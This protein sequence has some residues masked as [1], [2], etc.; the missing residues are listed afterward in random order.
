MADE[1]NGNF[2]DQPEKAQDGPPEVDLRNH[3]HVPDDHG[4]DDLA[5]GPK[6]TSDLDPASEAGPS[7]SDHSGPGL[8]FEGLSTQDDPL[9]QGE[10]WPGP[11]DD[12]DDSHDDGH[13][14]GAD[15]NQGPG[16][17]SVKNHDDDHKPTAPG[18]KDFYEESL[19]NE[20]LLTPGLKYAILGV[21]FILIVTLIYFI[22]AKPQRPSSLPPASQTQEM[23]SSP[24]EIALSETEA[25]EIPSSIR[26][27]SLEVGIGPIKTP[28]SLA[29]TDQSLENLLN[30]QVDPSS[31]LPGGWNFAPP[32]ESA[33]EAQAAPALD[34]PSAES[35]VADSGA[36]QSQAAQAPAQAPAQPTENAELSPADQVPDQALELSPTVP[37]A[38]EVTI[39]EANDSGSMILAPDQVPDQAPNLTTDAPPRDAPEAAPASA[40]IESEQSLEEY[41]PGDEKL[42]L[43]SEL[44]STEI[45][46]PAAPAPE[47]APAPKVETP[48]PAVERP[49][50][51][52]V[53]TPA[54]APAPAPA[55]ERPPAPKVETPA[56]AP[57]PAPSAQVAPTPA[58]PETVTETS[59]PAENLLSSFWVANL[60]STPSKEEADLAWNRLQAQKATD[61]LYRYEVEI[62]GTN[63]HRLRLGFFPDTASAQAAGKE[64]A[65]KAGL[66]EPWIV[67]PTVAEYGQYNVQKVS[68]LYAVNI[69]ST[70]DKAESEAIWGLLN[71]SQGL[72]A[73]KKIQGQNPQSALKLYRTETTVNE[74]IQYRIR[75]GFFDSNPAAVAA[76]TE[77]AQAASL[78]QSRIG[79]PWAVRP[80]QSE[81][82]ANL[83]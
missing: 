68:N 30:T 77:L 52:K 40:L 70:P 43:V 79:Q 76:G 83:K 36:P 67:R 49:P 13:D 18:Q 80:N 20:P 38:P 66:K 32:T 16:A 54:P 62:E 41:F 46:E 61:I 53:E 59:R 10:A 23:V 44:V 8:D 3:D 14:D 9:T 55:V 31:T 71:Q 5:Q 51:P 65:Q 26:A 11:G 12:Q 73:L 82:E 56:P 42:P 75:L 4:P 64:L 33:P 21:C 48:A 19:P 72:E 57:A 45:V 34:P 24:E 58:A 74:V 35:L 7:Y 50:A 29:A 28:E 39:I 37:Q 78:N 25:E 1:K 63:Q 15:L 81:V 17:L 60:L 22:I 47:I 6:F 69:S 27:G 2:N